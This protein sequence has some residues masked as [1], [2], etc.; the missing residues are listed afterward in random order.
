LVVGELFGRLSLTLFSARL[1]IA[2]ALA[3]NAQT[4]SE[5]FIANKMKT[6][7]QRE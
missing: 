6:S 4:A 7:K 5:Y 3:A 1:D 2:E